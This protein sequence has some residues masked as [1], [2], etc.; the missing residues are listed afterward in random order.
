MS[1]I[2]FS[3]LVSTKSSIFSVAP[4]L[5]DEKVFSVRSLVRGLVDVDGAKLVGIFFLVFGWGLFLL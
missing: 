5:L 3:S 2:F 1:R 4:R